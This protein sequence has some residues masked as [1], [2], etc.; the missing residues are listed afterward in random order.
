MLELFIHASLLIKSILLILSG[1][2]VMSWGVI[3]YKY[4]HLQMVSSES[5]QILKTLQSCESSG[6]LS[7]V[8]T[9]VGPLQISP[10]AAMARAVT[11]TKHRSREE[12][13]RLLKSCQAEETDK[14]ESYLIFLATVGATAPF[15]GLLGTVWGIMD[16]FKGIGTAGSASLAVVAPAIAEALV[17]TAIGLAAAIPSVMAYNFFLNWVRRLSNTLDA[18]SDAFQS[19]LIRKAA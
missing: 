7:A 18:F 15:I 2:S 19:L 14:L 9:A 4:L 17:S 3:L 1:L 16:A 11:R 5:Q 6:D 10:L 12:I 13:Q 8:F